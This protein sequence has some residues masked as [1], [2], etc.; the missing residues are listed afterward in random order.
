MQLDLD[1]AVSC[2]LLINELITNAV[3]HAF[4][5]GAAGVVHVRLQ[6]QPGNLCRLTVQDN[7]VGM[8]DSAAHAGSLGLQL[9]QD[10]GDQLNGSR[11]V[12]TGSGTGGTVVTIVFP[13][14]AKDGAA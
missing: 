7:G 3:K 12:D 6:R 1:R 11:R 2:G 13:L 10:L 9:I 8:A 4:A 14:D 5:P